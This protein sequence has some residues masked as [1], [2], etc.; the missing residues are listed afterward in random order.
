MMAY[1]VKLW[2]N[3]FRLLV[4][5]KQEISLAEVY[6][7]EGKSV[8]SVCKKAQKRQQMHCMAA[9]KSG[10]GSGFVICS[11]LK[12]SAFTAVKGRQRS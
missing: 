7:R 12:D 11:Y 4:Y 9:I 1:T 10:K 2:G 6:E 5:E 3:F 8:I